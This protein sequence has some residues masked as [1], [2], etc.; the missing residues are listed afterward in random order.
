MKPKKLLFTGLLSLC[1][2]WSSLHPLIPL[3]A[4][5]NETIDLNKGLA[6][7]WEFEEIGDRTA[8]NT[9]SLGGQWDG[10]LDPGN[11]VSIKNSND[12]AYGGVLHFEPKQNND[13]KGMLIQGTN[14]INTKRDNFTYSFW[15]KNTPGYEKRTVILQQTGN[16]PTLLNLESGGKYSVYMSKE[17]DKFVTPETVDSEWNLITL[18][19]ENNA[20]Q[21][22]ATIKGYVNGQ[23]TNTLNLDL[24]KFSAEDSGLYVGR[25]KAANQ[26]TGQFQGD[27]DDLR[28][29]TR[30]VS[31]LEVKAIFDLKAVD[32]LGKELQQK[33]DEATKLI[34]N[35]KVPSTHPA[36]VAL[37]NEIEKAKE[38]LASK[39]TTS[40]QAAILQLQ[41]KIEAYEHASST[42]QDDMNRGLLGLWT[43]DDASAPLKNGAN[44]DYKA[45][46]T[47][48]VTVK[49]KA[50]H[51]QPNTAMSNLDIS[52]TN[53]DGM[54]NS[55]SDDFTISMITKR[56][57]T[58]KMNLLQQTG[59][60]RSLLYY[61]NNAYYTFINGKDDKI[62]DA[63]D[64]NTWEHIIFVKSGRDPYTITMYINGKKSDSVQMHGNLINETTKLL[65]GSHKSA[66]DTLFHGDI[67]QLRVYNRAVSNTEAESLYKESS[68]IIDQQT[69]KDMKVQLDELIKDAQN[70]ID[71]NQME[72][73][74]PVRI[75]LKQAIS[76]AKKVSE[77]AT[78][79]ESL[80]QAYTML[81]RA[82][83][84]YIDATAELTIYADDV[85]R[86]VDSGIFGIN[87]RYGFNGYGSF[88]SSSMQMKD[89]FTKLY[90]QAGFGSLRYPGGTISNLFNW[91]ETIGPKEQ[92]VAQI[93]GFYNNSGQHGLLPNFGL[94]EVADF[95]QK[96][97]SELVYV[98]GLGRGDAKDAADL[99]E[100]LNAEVGDNP[101][102][103][104]AWA[105]VR[106]NNGHPKPY[107]VRYFEIGNE[108]NQG[109]ADG[110]SSQQYWTAYVEGGSENAYINGGVVNIKK[111]YAV[112]KDDWNVSSSY[113]NGNAS[114]IFYMRYA[115]VKEDT[116]A[117]YKYYYN[118]GGESY[119]A[120]NKDSVA[121]FVGDEQWQIVSKDDMDHHNGTAKVAWVDYRD[122]SIHFGDGTHGAIP[123]KD[124]QIKV[125]YTANRD[126]FVQVSKA[127][128]DTMQQ[129]NN[130]HTN[131]K[132]KEKE[133]HIYTSYE[134][135]G[136]IEK[137]NTQG[138][139]NL[140]DGMTI[141]PYSGTPAGGS[142]N[143][144]S[145]EQFYYDA[146]QKGNNQTEHVKDYVNTM[147]RYDKNKVPVISEYG[148][149][150][151]TDP[152][153]RSQTHAL[154]I[155]RAI[156][157]YVKLGSPYIQKHCL[158][159][160]YSEGADS[161]GPTQ[162]AVIQA[163][164][165][166]T[167]N[168]A[169]GEGEFKFF[170]TP[171]ANVFEMLN[172]NFGDSIVASN[173]TNK[174]LQHKIDQYSVMSSKDDDGNVYAA[175]VNLN[176]EQ[177]SSISINIEGIDIRGKEIEIYQS[178]GKSFY[179]ENT[180][181]NPNNVS[182]Q[183]T[184]M[185]MDSKN[186]RVTLAPHSF[187]I[188][189]IKKAL[190]KDDPI[191]N[192]SELETLI[193]ESANLQEKD[194]TA[195]SWKVFADALKNAKEALTSKDQALIDTAVQTLRKAKAGL[196]PDMP[197]KTDTSKLESII[198]NAISDE[199]ANE[200]TSDSW[201]NYKKALEH[202]KAILVN[203]S[204]NQKAIDQ[205]YQGVVDAMQ[206]LIRIPVINGEVNPS[207]PN[208][209]NVQ[210]GGTIQDSEAQHT[211][212][213]NTNDT[214]N[215]AL[216]A[217]I[218]ILSGSILAVCVVKS[219][220][221]K[222]NV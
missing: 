45:T 143:E 191:V 44:N 81:Q 68:D 109:G 71:K 32:T 78:E 163:V 130:Y 152:M 206:A 139:N 111:Q 135:K 90:K 7:H 96:N 54:L 38:A 185:R 22:S 69:M 188:I 103:G 65:I 97:D 58:K 21:S 110:N 151:S 56:K 144:A 118:Q 172:S 187:T 128:R 158:V 92:R 100:Y 108:M 59:S 104:I 35:G 210:N 29:Y 34:S 75:Q 126:G 171:S 122:G 51:F 196:I 204:A 46:L 10:V 16:S 105:E 63:G 53:G 145:K 169:T 114:Q 212:S 12:E 197:E 6:G 133:M 60:G 138:M 11:V 222:L 123:P 150:R 157:D 219:K 147:Q 4:V 95:V 154:Y 194:Y 153:V 193:A 168:T 15:I 1:T 209:P 125:S 162:Q 88:D 184:T 175:I 18:T 199:H 67:D 190:I 9:G 116:T 66:T 201:N 13:A 94:S 61:N 17:N 52:K 42:P 73:T 177:P 173:I 82:L 27:M 218:F 211:Q 142:S 39:D 192:T 74:E 161:L 195:E 31:D 167:G 176:L 140:Y 183:H 198:K 132:N 179:A 2:A 121:V 217:W 24:S 64:I 181:E 99:V 33:V 62:A 120:V 76:Q 47:G 89:D 55:A 80:K 5:Q 180:L 79:T 20:D 159:D 3:Q 189:K 127:M 41:V 182:I 124:K 216:T 30:A 178:A 115:R 23:L 77:Q 215:T 170:S 203:S 57:D 208:M 186:E 213:P 202:A 220:K 70:E 43:F 166:D 117:D 129:I 136:F 72:D 93:H 40:M 174:K 26:Q 200:Y 101:N 146:M 8:V 98:Y 214:M 155:A 134:S 148:I 49:E 91:K 207:I 36:A 131:H 25:H 28:Y 160:W 85:L 86:G 205:A 112:A 119:D 50:L 83:E 102:G 149:F 37:Q 48:D 19:K 137:M 221:K 106:A 14:K 141:H 156:M 164:P 165:M 87:H 113:S 84:D 107:N